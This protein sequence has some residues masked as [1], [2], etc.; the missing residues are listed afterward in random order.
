NASCNMG[1]GSSWTSGRLIVA[2]PAGVS[3]PPPGFAF[4]GSGTY[5]LPAVDTVLRNQ[6]ALSA[7]N[8]LNVEDSTG[9]AINVIA[10]SAL[11]QILPVGGA[12]GSHPQ[13][14]IKLCDAKYISAPSTGT[15]SSNR[16]VDI[17]SAGSTSI[18]SP[19]SPCP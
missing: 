12:T 3:S 11:G 17:S 18:V 2:D 16:E 10:F 13:I 4:P 15:A 9:S 5:A 8:T 14:K 7:G 1:A 19:P 6:P